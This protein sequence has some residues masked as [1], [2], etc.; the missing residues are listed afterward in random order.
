MLAVSN[1]SPIS[2]LASIDRL[3]LLTNQF[4]AIWI[5]T[6]VEQELMDHPDRV[7][8][9]AIH[10][11]LTEQRVRVKAP[12]ESHLLR[13]LA[14]QLHRGEAEAIALAADLKADMVVID[15]QEGR[16]LAAQA[17]LS[18]IGVL[19]VL[20]HAKRN[21]QIPAVK[22]ELRLLRDKAH[23]FISQ[24]LEAKVLSAAGE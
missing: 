19:G 8:R 7:A 15:E 5:P 10:L 6:A 24:T 12:Q 13:I 16:Q 1:T 21:G 4:S 9:E 20:L 3:D 17:G 2:N 18:V 23:F 22:P 11:A 14:P